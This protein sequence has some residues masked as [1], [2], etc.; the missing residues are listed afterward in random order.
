VADKGPDS[1]HTEVAQV[2]VEHGKCNSFNGWCDCT[3]SMVD[4]VQSVDANRDSADYSITSGDL[5]QVGFEGH[6]VSHL[7]DSVYG[8]YGN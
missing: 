7:G 8:D 5:A 3:F 2:I 4:F 1:V 6:G